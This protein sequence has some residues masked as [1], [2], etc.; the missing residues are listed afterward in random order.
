MKKI[1]SFV[2]CLCMMLTLSVSVFA[3]D[4]DVMVVTYS[5]ANGSFEDR[6]SVFHDGWTAAI[7][8]S[9]DGNYSNVTVTLLTDWLSDD[10]GQFT[11]DFFNKD[12]FNWDAIDFPESCTI[13][14]DL[15]GYKID[16]KLT[17]WEYNGEVM[18][19]NSG[20]N[21]TIKNGSISGGYSAN[22]AG[23]IHVKGGNLT[24]E[25]VN[26]VNNRVEDDYGAGIAVLGGT[27]KMTGGSIKN[28]I[29]EVYGASVYG[30]GIYVG[31]GNVVLDGV[32]I[33]GNVATGFPAS[34]YGGGIF[35]NNSATL[36]LKNCVIKNNSSSG[37][38]GAIH[39]RNGTLKM[40]NCT[41][42]DNSTDTYGGGIF[43]A[44]GSCTIS[45]CNI[46]DN[47]AG[48]AASAVNCH[49][50]KIKIENSY[51]DGTVKDDNNNIEWI[52]RIENAE[53]LPGTIVS[54]GYIVVIVAAAA[55]V[56][57]I[58]AVVIMKKRK[59]SAAE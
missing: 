13:T 31:G 16:R 45:G 49:K 56:I 23:G 47:K 4:N 9:V 55:V 37:D 7:K 21:V 6:Y 29:A 14:L 25:N 57:A 50:T 33:S 17:E 48:T 53:T 59:T 2:L 30:G 32:E 5:T 8:K 12:G 22:G 44:E 52:N 42:T 18:C 46:Y 39:H 43:S 15:G 34:T 28:N 1:I 41:V 40:T 54:G 58:V 19:V 38:G 20:T 26:I 36:E 24:L 35:V 10:D 11:P 3:A 27:V 51:V